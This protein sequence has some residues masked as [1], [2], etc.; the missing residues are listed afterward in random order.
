MLHV[1][2]SGRTGTVWLAVH[3]GLE[4]Y[5]AIK[6]VSRASVDYET[7]R[8]EALILKDLRHP[9]IPMIY[10]LEEDSDY[11]Y[12]IEEYLQ[13]YSLYTLITNQGTLQEADAV[14]YGMQ[15]CGLV[16]YLH[17]ADEIPI[18]YLDLQPNNLIICGGA[19]KLIDF[20]HALGS[21]QANADR[22][23]YGTRGCAAPEQYTSDRILDQRTDIYAIGAVLRFMVTG[24]LEQ[25]SVVSDAISRPFGRI[26]MKCME[27]DMERR[28]TSAKEVGSVLQ[29]LCV[30]EV[31]DNKD[32]KT[33]PSLVLILVGMRPGA[34]TTHLAFGMCVY[35]AA[36]G[37][38]VLYEEHNPSRAVSAL[39]LRSGARS[40]QYGVYHINGC[41]MKPWYGP[42]VRLEKPVGYQV[43]VK[44]CGTDWQLAEKELIESS[45]ILITAAAWNSWEMD[46]AKHLVSALEDMKRRHENLKVIFVF[47][48]MTPSRLKSLGTTPGMGCLL[49]ESVIF[50]TPEYKDPFKQ[51]EEEKAFIN[52]VWSAISGRDRLEHIKRGWF[53]RWMES[54]RVFLNAARILLANAG[55][56]ESLEQDAE[57]E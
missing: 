15:I 47:R 43:I 3:L 5:R 14:R 42:A 29:K 50:E 34:G 1:L 12:L 46:Y 17:S 2:G 36:Q 19:V 16:E 54:E 22:K 30:R 11:F 41:Y 7:F 23:R 18:L 9:G 33:I 24:T 10:D 48:H 57:Q 39:A 31:S 53:R 21:L 26:I 49:K 52:T 35:L 32:Y 20:D 56:S 8:R 27:P 44:D 51:Q 45:G 40:D 37:Y 38:R 6:R 55:L 25:G 13:G 28:Y 4:E